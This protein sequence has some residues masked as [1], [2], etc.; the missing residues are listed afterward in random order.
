MDLAALFPKLDP[1]GVDLMKRMLE[2]DPIK[3]IS[4]RPWLLF[5]HN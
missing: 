3:R 5:S 4:V 2:Y 1:E